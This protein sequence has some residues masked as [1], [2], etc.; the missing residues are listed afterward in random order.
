MTPENLEVSLPLA[1]PT[2]RALALFIDTYLQFAV[3]MVLT[4]IVSVLLV[5]TTEEFLALLP[6]LAVGFSE[7][8]F[9]GFE[10]ARNGQTP[11][12]RALGLR[13]LRSDGRSL[14][15]AD[16][17]LRNLLRAV[18]WLPFG[19]ALG[20]VCQLLGGRHQRMGD[21][22]AGTV[23]VEENPLE[24]W[25]TLP[26][27][28]HRVPQAHLLRPEDLQWIHRFQAR[29]TRLTPQQRQQ[30]AQ[31]LAGALTRR[32]QMEVPHPRSSEGVLSDLLWSCEVP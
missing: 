32:L 8:Y 10:L 25:H 31:Y 21:L 19:Y 27:P 3:L 18:D 14:T 26:P 2:S 15:T 12:K 5:P 20:L 30:A 9:I 7:L 4:W 6:A 22:I 13:V 16:S 11:G 23:V 17:L 29:A 28:R 1:G 24:G